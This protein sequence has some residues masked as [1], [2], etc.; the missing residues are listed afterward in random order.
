MKSGGKQLDDVNSKDATS[1]YINMVLHWTNVKFPNWH[2]S[3]AIRKM[4]LVE[5]RSCLKH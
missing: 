2:T 4:A 5:I 3:L 1:L